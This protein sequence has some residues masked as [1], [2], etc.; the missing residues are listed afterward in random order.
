[1]LTNADLK[2]ALGINTFCAIE[3]VQKNRKQK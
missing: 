3:L 1:L 2:F